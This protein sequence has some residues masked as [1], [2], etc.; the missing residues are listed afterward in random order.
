MVP[1]ISILF[2]PILCVCIFVS[3]YPFIISIMYLAITP[4]IYYFCYITFTL[5]VTF[6]MSASDT[7]TITLTSTVT[8]SIIVTVTLS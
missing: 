8:V 7:D 1:P 4:R 3:I 6:T 2:N 5:D